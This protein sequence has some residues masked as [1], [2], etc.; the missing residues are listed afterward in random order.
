MSLTDK[1][2]DGHVAEHNQAQTSKDDT[3]AAISNEHN[4]TVRQSIRFWWKAIVFS[5]VISLAVVMEGYDTS[6]MN[7]FFAFDPFKNRFGDQ[8]DA[9]G[10]PLVSARWQTIILNGTQVGCILGLIIN[11]Y[12]TEWIGYKKTMIVSML[13]MIGAVFIPFFSTSLEMFLIGGI[14]QGLPWGVFQTLAISYAAD[15]CPTHLRGYMTSWINMCWVIGGLLSTGILTGL[16]KNTTQWGYRIPFALQWIWPIPILVATLLCPESPWWLVRQGRV[17]EAKAAI[18]SLTTPSAGIE[19]DLDSHIEMMVVTNAF[20]KE[21]SAGTNYWHLFRGS[22]LHRTEI[23]AMAFVTQALC[24]VPFMGFGTQFMQGTGI[25][26]DDS[27]HLTI[28]QDCLGLVGCFIAWWIMTRF[29]RRSMY[30]IGL[31][32]ISLILLIVGFIGLAPETN[33]SASMAGGILIILMIFS[34]QLSIG[35]ICYTLAAEIP[36]SQLR[37]KTVALSRATYNSIVF[38]TN[39]IMPKMVG[40]NEWNWGAKGGFFWAGIAVLFIIWGYFRLP[41]S[42]GLTYS[43]LDLLFEHK[44]SSRQFSREKADLLKPSLTEKAMQSEKQAAVE[45]TE[46]TA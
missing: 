24:G 23:S 37:V 11:G 6:L 35:P 30:L 41:E 13:A 1:N 5:F 25:S 22:D 34:F 19:F 12:I 29:G 26:Q 40:K 32:V 17:E 18:A 36:S 38:V 20:E 39:T 44:V 10:N 9:D 4:M 42:H 3:N 15:L 46:S 27:F 33:K 2:L 8:K 16:M 43:E 14:I 7:K 28:G 45:R 31:S 21:V